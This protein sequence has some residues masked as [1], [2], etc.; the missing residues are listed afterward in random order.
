MRIAVLSLLLLIFFSSCSKKTDNGLFKEASDLES[1]KD[2]RRSAEL[3]ESVVS[4][5]PTSMYAESSLIHLSV[6]YN[7]VL[8]DARLAIH[9]YQRCYTMFP[10]STQA[11]TMLFLSGFVYNNELHRIDSARMIYETFLQ[12]YPTHELA[13]SAKFELETLGQDPIEALKP[14]VAKSDT[15]ETKPQKKATKK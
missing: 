14:I 12:K 4:Q 3:F 1:K 9:T 7:N 10:S 6:L 2:F 11:P 13:P 15:P 8:K 5:F